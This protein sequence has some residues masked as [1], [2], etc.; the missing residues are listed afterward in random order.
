MN[1]FSDPSEPQQPFLFIS[2][3]GLEPIE[4]NSA[5]VAYVLN[6]EI[7]TTLTPEMR[8]GTV[9][10]QFFH[11]PGW[12]MNEDEAKGK[13]L[14]LNKL[15][16]G[17]VGKGTECAE[18][19][20]W[21]GHVRYHDNCSVVACPGWEHRPRRSRG[22]SGVQN[23]DEVPCSTETFTFDPKIDFPRDSALRKYYSSGDEGTRTASKPEDADLSGTSSQQISLSVVLYRPELGTE[24]T[25]EIPVD[26]LIRYHLEGEDNPVCWGHYSPS[27]ARQ[28][29]KGETR[30]NENISHSFEQNLEPVLQRLEKESEATFVDWTGV[31]FSNDPAASEVVAPAA[32]YEEPISV[33]RYQ[34]TGK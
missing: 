1:S 26:T 14:V 17:P 34:P 15:T 23:G 5:E 20:S 32:D 27:S 19:W 3:P 29:K 12:P 10:E 25:K 28:A 2:R 4:N 16:L 30:C 24:A 33:I 11:L 31:K 21:D 13:S 18:I 22:F 8:M 9:V 7:E 6:R